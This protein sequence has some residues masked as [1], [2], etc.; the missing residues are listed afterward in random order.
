MVGLSALSGALATAALGARGGAEVWLGMMAPLVVVSGTWIITARTFR[1]N[2]ERVT[3]LMMTAFVGKLVLFGVYVTLVIGVFHVRPMPFAVSFAS[4]FI[5]L[6][7]A[8]AICLQRLFAERMRT[9]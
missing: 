2:P 1:R 5:A 4:Y 9:A 7:M 3:S 8:E 6:H